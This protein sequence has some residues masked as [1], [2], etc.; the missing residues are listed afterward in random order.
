MT[1]EDERLTL[2]SEVEDEFSEP[3][4]RLETALESVDQEIRDTGGGGSDEIT[5]DAEAHTGAAI[6]E[7]EA[8][9]AAIENIDDEVR[10]DVDVDES[11]LL[12]E[13]VSVNAEGRGS[14]FIE[15]DS[16]QFTS[17]DDAI[18]RRFA[19]MGEAVQRDLTV[20]GDVDI[21][22]A[23]ADLQTPQADVVAGTVDVDS[24]SAADDVDMDVGD[25]NLQTSQADVDVD[26][27][28]DD[29]QIS[30][31]D[32][33]IG[34]I[35]VDEINV[36]D[37]D[38]QT[39]QADV[40][41]GN[42]DV[43]SASATGD[44]G[45]TAA[46]DGDDDSGS[47]LFRIENID[48][49]E[50]D[51]RPFFEEGR[52]AERGG[53]AG[54]TRE[55]TNRP[56]GEVVDF[57]RLERAVRREET[58]ITERDVR[59]VLGI[60]GPE[61]FTEAVDRLQDFDDDIIQFRGEQDTRFTLDNIDEFED[62]LGE[63]FDDTALIEEGGETRDVREIINRDIEDLVD[64][65]EVIRLA[66][67]EDTDIDMR[68]VRGI[69]GEGTMPEFFDAVEELN[70]VDPDVTSFGGET[71]RRQLTRTTDELRF[72]IQ[73]FHQIFAAMVPL[74]GVFI[75]A[76]PAAITALGGLAAAAIGAAGVLGAIGGLGVIGISLEQTGDIG[77]DPIVEELQSLGSTFKDAF[78]P[79]AE[80][81]AP[82]IRDFI[83]EMEL[84]AGPLATASSALLEFRGMFEGFGQFLGDALPSFTRD[85]LAF[86]QAAMPVLQGVFNTLA[87]VDIFGI[88]ANNLAKALP[89][90]V[91]MGQSLMEILPA[92]LQV[93]HGFLV[94]ASVLTYV[95]GVVSTIINTV[96]YL[97][98]VL[99]ILAGAFLT[100]TAAATMYNLA[101]TSTITLAR[102]WAATA[103]GTLLT[104]IKSAIIGFAQ[105]TATVWGLSSSLLVSIALTATLIGLLTGG[106]AIAVAGLA[107]IFDNLTDSIGGARQELKQFQN[108]GIDSR[109]P[110]YAEPGG[111]GDS[112]VYRDNS[113]TI[114]NANDR[115][116]ASRQ[117]Y[118]SE[119]EQGQR[120]DS[121]F[122]SGA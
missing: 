42:V 101:Q 55:I 91:L 3:L 66:R 25:D 81:F 54:R 83:T 121:V 112:N 88:L 56:I 77:L 2:T 4:E 10:I 69:T 1:D 65:D 84:M 71:R 48:E 106:L 39:P 102:K 16:G 85:F 105:L 118:R 75:G 94:V 11:D 57:G 21:D 30:Q 38:L 87:S 120:I 68:T 18:D 43:D 45:A 93:S 36:S 97:G 64:V 23:D 6:G 98:E 50:P 12:R 99:G 35:D 108:E 41:A 67:D 28:D 24:P 26:V 20:A 15:D 59:G 92:I 90:L 46:T 32:V 109:G 22:V 61:G 76:L 13:D 122:G 78:G 53:A 70:D 100:L 51:M 60:D 34:N 89:M 72:T 115:D 117:Q 7:L 95:V 119:Y 31:A 58:D 104:G 73:R 29:L 17:V 49:F 110:A 111:R 52:L 19:E 14:Q 103:A 62:V 79:L 63:F 47:D 8:L 116:S 114:I 33:T 107:S 113:T 9:E 27:A 5:I 80:S 86:T 96:P 82:I 74:F 40:A 37:A 44:G